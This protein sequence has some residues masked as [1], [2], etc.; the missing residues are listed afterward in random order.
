MAG[1][2]FAIPTG[3]VLQWFVC[4]LYF[5]AL[6]GFVIAK[7]AASTKIPLFIVIARRYLRLTIPMLCSTLLA[8]VLLKMF[9]GVTQTAAKQLGN[10]WLV[11]HY[12]GHA[13]TLFQATW[14][15]VFNPY[16]FGEV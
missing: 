11:D 5:F 12:Y 10:D 9:P 8:Y 1:R 14:D 4:S 6:S 2:L 3:R 7:S 15:A 13:L 16:R